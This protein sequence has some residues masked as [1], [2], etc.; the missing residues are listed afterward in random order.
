MGG[1]V[2]VPFVFVGVERAGAIGHGA[3]CFDWVG[4][5]VGGWMRWIEEAKAVR[6]SY[7]ELGVGWV[8]GWVGCCLLDINLHVVLP[9]V[10]FGRVLDQN[11]LPITLEEVGGWVVELMRR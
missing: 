6:T 10:V 9:T 7:W 3:T 5:W 8:G 2:N 1:W 11:G 4:G